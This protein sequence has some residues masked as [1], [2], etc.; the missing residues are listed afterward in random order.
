MSRAF[1][2]GITI[3]TR[4]W[5]WFAAAGSGV[6]AAICFPPL[7]A[8]FL[9]W[10]ALTPLIAAI[11]FS[12]QNVRRRWLRNLLLGYVSGLV[13]FTVSFS[14]LGSLGRL[15]ESLPLYGLPAL[16]SLYL[17]MHWAF[18]AW[19]AG[20]I[21]PRVFTSS[22]RNLFCALVGASAWTA[23]EWLRGWLFGGFGWN[24]LGVTQYANWLLIQICEFTGVGGLSFAI[25]FFNI[26]AMTIPL[27][28]FTEA[29]SRQMRPHWDL[30]LSVLGIF[31]LWVYG[32][33][34]VGETRP[35]QPLRV[36]AIQPNIAQKE[37]FQLESSE[38]VFDQLSRLS[39]PLVQAANPPQ[40][41]IWPESATP[42]PMV[43][44]E[45]TYRFVMDFRATSP[46]DLLL[47]SDVVD[48]GQAFNAAVLV[49]VNADE[50]QVYRK[51]HLVPFGEYVPL[52]HSFPLFAAIAGRWVPGD[53]GRGQEY[54]RFVLTTAPVRIA[55]LIC[56]EDTIG[57]LTRRFVLPNAWDDRGA[58]LLVNITNDGWFL[59]SA[60]SHQHLANAVFRCVETRRPM[61][62][63]A[64]TGVTCFINE[65]GRV[66]Q[67]LK[68]ERGST[69]TEGALSGV[70]N[71]PLNG[72]ITFYVLH[73]ELFSQI[74][75]GITVLTLIALLTG[76][77]RRRR[78][79]APESARS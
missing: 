48:N 8:N 27:R 53:F 12:G 43:N 20:F 78:A 1:P 54:S 31:G 23:H 25:A 10:I 74:C 30:N 17:A 67:T 24:G 72:G 40:L 45:Q 75:A 4:L 19:F 77:M 62:R 26:V 76:F 6:L 63:A 35:T 61:V 21:K 56:F 46:A 37:K 70:I 3:L 60:G 66:T 71:V 34:A 49:P 14:W 51:I 22:W 65:F 9:V 58:D 29:R 50:L 64:N 73:G 28:L 7:S 57:E 79:P 59:H 13:F 15:F 42:A 44:D 18:W 68:D 39:R 36:A 32:W 52:R 69:F 38:R 33:N 41:L 16:L 2:A 55:P 47:G 11:W 5:P